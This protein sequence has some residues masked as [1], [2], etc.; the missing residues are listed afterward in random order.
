M[1]EDDSQ[2]ATENYTPLA[3]SCR[4]YLARVDCSEDILENPDPRDCFFAAHV[5][6]LHLNPGQERVSKNERRGCTSIASDIRQDLRGPVSLQ[7]T[8]D[9]S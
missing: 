6:K 5:L 4:F 2:A 3:V 8:H 7:S 1:V 9:V